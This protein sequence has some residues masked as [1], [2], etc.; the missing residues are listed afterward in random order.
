MYVFTG[1]GREDAAK[2]YRTLQPLATNAYGL[3]RCRIPE[4]G[5]SELAIKLETVKTLFHTI[6]VGWNAEE[7]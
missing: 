1:S 2:L 7:Y 5:S 3:Y 6:E 4:N